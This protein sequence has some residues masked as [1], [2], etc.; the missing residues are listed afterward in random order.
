[1]A[2]PGSFVPKIV[3][4]KEKIGKRFNRF[5]AGI[6]NPSDRWRQKRPGIRETT[7]EHY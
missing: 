6:R 1:M 2:L 7:G 5:S 4:R 3:K